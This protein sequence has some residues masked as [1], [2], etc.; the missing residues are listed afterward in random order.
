MRAPVVA[1]LI[2]ALA[3]PALAGTC[4]AQSGGTVTPVLE[5]YTSE[6]CSACPLADRY[7]STLRN[8]AGGRAVV[9]AFHVGLWDDSGWVDRFATPAHLARQRQVAAWNHL[10]KVFT[11]Q[12]VLNG[13]NWQEWLDDDANPLAAGRP[14]Q[15]AIALRQLD[16]N[17]FEARVTPAAK[18]PSRWSAYWT[19]TE[20]GH[21]SNVSDGDNVGETLKHDFVVRQYIPAG[22][23]STEPG[24]AKTLVFRSIAATPGHERQVNLVVFD[25]TTGKTV[26]AL[27]AGC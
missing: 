7:V 3:A 22:D 1:L 19:V 12:L 16:T 26:Q 15:A 20:H 13:S 24:Q 25:P 27:S 21:W 5:L 8:K 17:Y 14:A 11:P 10:N 18:A 23:Y 9:Q 2:A 4:T 6:A